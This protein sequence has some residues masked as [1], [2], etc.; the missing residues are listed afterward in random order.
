MKKTKLKI[1][2]DEYHTTCG[3][4]CCTDYRTVTYVNGG[5]TSIP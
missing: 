5:R 2:L 1:T 4:G 3:D